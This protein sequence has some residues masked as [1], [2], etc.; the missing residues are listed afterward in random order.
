MS[1][2][3]IN[4]IAHS[5]NIGEKPRFNHYNDPGHSWVRVP[6][7]FIGYLMLQNRIS[8]YSYIKG[9]WI[10]L[11]T[12]CDYS[13]FLDAFRSHWGRKRDPILNDKYTDNISRIR[14]YTPYE[15]SLSN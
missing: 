6:L 3:E 2:R 10:Y 9:K 8:S 4:K 5:F 13:I 1:Y 12:D 14:Y 11:E 15:A 7:L